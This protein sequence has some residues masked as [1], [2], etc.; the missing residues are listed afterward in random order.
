MV[1]DRVG[2]IHVA[3]D[4]VI[5][6][7]AKYKT[8]RAAFVEMGRMHN[9]EKKEAAKNHQRVMQFAGEIMAIGTDDP[10]IYDRAKKIRDI[11]ADGVRQ[12]LIR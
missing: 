10:A 12:Y 5:D 4:T 6:W 11:S 3:G 8:C 9:R 1:R 7:E 2:G